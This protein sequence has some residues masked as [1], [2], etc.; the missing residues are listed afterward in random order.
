M[1]N[2]Q[3]KNYRPSKIDSAKR[4]AQLTNSISE[5]IES[6]KDLTEKLKESK[7]EY[8]NALVDKEVLEDEVEKTKEKLEN[9]KEIDSIEEE[10]DKKIIYM[11]K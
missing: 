2:L 4:R 3:I 6:L 7:S 1:K 5:D 11:K 8:T 10:I 9:S